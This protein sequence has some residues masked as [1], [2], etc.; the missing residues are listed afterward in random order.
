MKRPINKGI[1]VLLLITLAALLGMGCSSVGGAQ[2]LVK[3]GKVGE[4]IIYLAK[5]ITDK[6]DDWKAVEELKIHYPAY[7]TGLNARLAEI[8]AKKDSDPY[9]NDRLVPLYQELAEIQNALRPISGRVVGKD[10]KC[11]A[12]FEAD[13]RDLPG[14]LVQAKEG[15]AEVHYN[16]A[17]ALLPGAG[18]E[19]KKKILGEFKVV[20]GYVDRYK[21]SYNYM[22]QLGYEIADE[23]ALSDDVDARKTAIEWY[24]YALSYVADYRDSAQ[25]V[26]ALSFDVAEYYKGRGDSAS[27]DT[28]YAYYKKAGDF[29]TAAKEVALYDLGKAIAGLGTSATS[30]SG[31]YSLKTTGSATGVS[32]KETDQGREADDPLRKKVA[33]SSE[34]SDMNIFNPRTDVIYVGSLIDAQSIADGTYKPITGARSPLTVSIDLGNINGD[35][36]VLIEDPSRASSVQN[37]VNKLVQQGTSGSMAARAKFRYQEVKSSTHL[38]MGLGIGYGKGNV[39][40]ESQTDYSSYSEKSSTLVELT[41]V[42]YNISMDLPQKPSDLFSITG[43]LP[44]PADW[45]ATPYYVSTVTYGRRAYFLIEST[46]TTQDIQQTLGVAIDSVASN[47]SIDT[48]IQNTWSNSSTK[49]T[50][51]VLGGEARGANITSLEGIIGWIKSGMDIGSNLG[52]AVPIGYSM[53]SLKDNGI[54]M[55]VNSEE[56]VVPAR[57]E[58]VIRPYAI[59][60]ERTPSFNP[61]AEVELMVSKKSLRNPRYPGGLRNDTGDWAVLMNTNQSP[62]RSG[63]EE[64]DSGS[65]SRATDGPPAGTWEP[66][67]TPSPL[68]VMSETPTRSIFF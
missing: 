56:S 63:T 1:G 52:A 5:G 19:E 37:A 53:R 25:K 3:Q 23:A 41:Q 50:S 10:G 4:A 45:N 6:N 39:Q 38:Q 7:T 54:A 32:I 48:S 18:A 21:D 20:L 30:D 51:F 42:Y 9:Y 44:S 22:A 13:P 27:Y 64:S 15:A 24:E 68:P 11:T 29:K 33:L 17:V 46:A 8:L 59:M 67:T 55:I 14:F 65:A 12:T 47:T 36:S 60:C 34:A 66:T 49:I 28:A 57:A 58:V 31:N 62:S 2:N 26:K 16:D 35:A 43:R 40:L 61:K